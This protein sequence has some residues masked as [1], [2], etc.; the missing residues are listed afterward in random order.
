MCAGPL[1]SRFLLGLKTTNVPGYKLTKLAARFT[2]AWRASCAYLPLTPP[3]SLGSPLL[4]LPTG[5]LGG[6]RCWL[7]P[8]PLAPWIPAGSFPDPRTAG[9]TH[10]WAK[11]KG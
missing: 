4:G 10:I 3:L 9:S 5:I 11:A 7:F 1:G 2:W 6:F 8:E